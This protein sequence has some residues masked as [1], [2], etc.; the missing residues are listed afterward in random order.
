MCLRA[1]CHDC[2]RPQRCGD[3]RT[4]VPTW[5]VCRKYN[6]ESDGKDPKYAA[7]T[8]GAGVYRKFKIDLYVEA[9]DVVSTTDGT[10]PIRPA[11]VAAG[12]RRYA[13]AAFVQRPRAHC[14]DGLSTGA[15]R[16]PKHRA[17]RLQGMIS[18]IAHVYGLR[19]RM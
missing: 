19:T 8:T 2:S 12:T 17:C 14:I 3:L 6:R 10:Y 9:P 4:P 5:W 11:A 16:P 18:G 15:K 1:K 7:A 13:L